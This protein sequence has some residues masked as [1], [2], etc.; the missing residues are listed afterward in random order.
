MMDIT[1]LFE[2]DTATQ[3]SRKFTNNQLTELLKNVELMCFERQ[4]LRFNLIEESI[5]RV[6]K[7]YINSKLQLH[8]NMLDIFQNIFVSYCPQFNDFDY[9]NKLKKKRCG[10][11]QC[12]KCFITRCHRIC[13]YFDYGESL[14]EKK[15]EADSEDEEEFFDNCYCIQINWT[16]YDE[17]NYIG[18]SDKHNVSIQAPVHHISPPPYKNYNERD[19]IYKSGKVKYDLDTGKV[20]SQLKSK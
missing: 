14:K 5:C 18:Y 8:P 7:E 13:I 12:K 19:A 15:Y 4:Q 3:I 6:L 1:N 2:Y 11:Q 16:R 10:H 20:K 17:E 9:F